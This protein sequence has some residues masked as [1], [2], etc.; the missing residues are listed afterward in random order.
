MLPTHVKCLDVNPDE[1]L[2]DGISATSIARAKKNLV[3]A[4]LSWQGYKLEVLSDKTRRGKRV[5][6]CK[7]IGDAGP[8]SSGRLTV[9]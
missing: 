3:G 4:T 1:N 6:T 9:L 7:Q 5:L 2:L 8:G